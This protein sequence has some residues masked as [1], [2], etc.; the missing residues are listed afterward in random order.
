MYIYIYMYTYIYIDTYIHTYTY[1]YT[2]MYRYSYLY[3][4]VAELSYDLPQSLLCTASRLGRH[5]AASAARPWVPKVM[6]KELDKDSSRAHSHNNNDDNNMYLCIY[7]YMYTAAYVYPSYAGLLF[8]NL[9]YVTSI[10]NV[11]NEGFRNY[12]ILAATHQSHE[13]GFDFV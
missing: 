10:G 6:R 9:V 12:G 7:M 13:K 8:R 5:G 11:P 4:F 1:I 3:L 2:C